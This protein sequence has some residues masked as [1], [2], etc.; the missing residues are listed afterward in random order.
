MQHLLSR[1]IFYGET[2][3]GTLLDRGYLWASHQRRLNKLIIIIISLIFLSLSDFRYGGVLASRV[4]VGMHGGYVG[5]TNHLLG[6][7]G[8]VSVFFS[9][10]IVRSLSPV[11]LPKL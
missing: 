7:V 10:P 11:F 9:L 1:F 2:V 5:Q 3:T 4:G 8:T 6:L